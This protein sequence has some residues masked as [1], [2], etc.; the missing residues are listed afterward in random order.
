VNE[1]EVCLYGLAK[2]GYDLVCWLPS[3]CCSNEEHCLPDDQL[4]ARMNVDP[5]LQKLDALPDA[6]R[7]FC[8][9][10]VQGFLGSMWY[11]R[12]RWKIHA[13]SQPALL[14][15]VMPKTSTTQAH[16]SLLL[17]L[18]YG[19]LQIALLPFRRRRALLHAAGCGL[20]HRYPSTWSAWLAWTARSRTA[21]TTSSRQSAA[22][23][24]TPSSFQPCWLAATAAYKQGTITR[25]RCSSQ[26][27]Y[28]KSR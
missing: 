18:T 10:L 13:G 15:K 1:C 26:T 24:R 5:Q 7:P 4:T 9:S 28:L 2:I 20:P 22:S 27:R 23:A 16:A 21:C 17:K 8:K 19:A 14:F 12:G 6:V 11:G 3:R 25:S